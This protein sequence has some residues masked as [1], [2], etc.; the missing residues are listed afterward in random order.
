MASIFK[1]NLGGTNYDLAGITPLATTGTSSTATAFVVTFQSI[2]ELTDGLAL[3]ITNTKVN[4][5]A[6]CTLN[7][8]S[9]GAKG[10]YLSNNGTRLSTEWPL[11]MTGLFVYSSALN[12]NAG[13]WIFVTGLNTDIN[14]QQNAAISTNGNYPVMLGG[15]T[16]TTAITGTLNKS[17]SLT[18]N[19]STGALSAS[20]F[21]GDG[22][23]ITNISA[24][25]VTLQLTG[26]VTGSVTANN[27]ITTTLKT[28]GV[29]SGTYGFNSSTSLSSNATFV[30]P[31]FQVDAKGRIVWAQSQELTMPNITTPPEYSSATPP[32]DG[33][34]SAGTNN[35]YYAAANHQHPSDTTRVAKNGD[36]M[37]GVLT[38]ASSTLYSTKQARN[39]YILA[40]GSSPSGGANGDVALFY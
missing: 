6:N 5:A 22:T 26:D 33:A 38:C 3:F 18:Y 35:R 32:M 40:D 29:T 36:T 28:T 15:T 14:V 16:A 2:G 19:P 27:S 30:V 9:L 39:I 34:G 21:I 7:V 12:N 20:S 11:N 31:N 10:I 13:G 8:N 4:S 1:I 24:D 37:T 23:S 25:K 17:S